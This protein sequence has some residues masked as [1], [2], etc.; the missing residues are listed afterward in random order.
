MLG[1][2]GKFWRPVVKCF[3]AS[4][5]SFP[6]LANPGYGKVV[7]STTHPYPSNTRNRV[8]DTGRAN[9]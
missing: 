8:G 7:W 9:G 6:D 2:V 3:R 4:R 1:A 5:A